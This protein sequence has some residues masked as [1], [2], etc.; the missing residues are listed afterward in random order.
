MA[1]YT[2]YVHLNLT[3][4]IESSITYIAFAWTLCQRSHSRACMQLAARL[5][6]RRPMLAEQNEI[7]Y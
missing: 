4:F 3:E 2:D 5:C 1:S 7:F 6:L